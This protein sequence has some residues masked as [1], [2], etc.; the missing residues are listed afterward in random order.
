MSEDTAAP[1]PAAAPVNKNKKYRRDKRTGNSQGFAH[2]PAWDNET[3]DH[4]KIEPFTQVLRVLLTHCLS[5]RVKGDMKA[6]LLEESSFATLFPKY[7]EQYLRCA[8]VRFRCANISAA[9]YGLK[10]RKR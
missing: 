10:L 7:R 2:D 9:K 6:P 4:W 1:E 5:L 8:R 3:I